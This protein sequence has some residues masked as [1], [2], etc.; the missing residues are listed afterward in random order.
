MERVIVMFSGGL[1]SRLAVKIM[2]EQG[3]EVLA[4]FFKLPFRSGC[5]NNW[6]DFGISKM[7]NVEFRIIDCTKGKNLR[8]YLEILRRPKFKRGS[9]INPCIDCRL[10]MFKKAREIADKE[11]IETIVSGEV[12]GERP[13]SQMQKSLDIVEEESG[14]KGRLLR[15]L[16]AKLLEETLAEKKGYVNR[17][18]LYDIEGRQRIKQ[19]ELAKKFNIKYPTPAGGCLLCEKSLSR[20]FLVL[21][22]KN[23]TEDQ[24]KI[25]GIGRH[26]IIDNK[27]VAI[28]RNLNENKLIVKYGRNYGVFVSNGFA[29][30]SAVL[31][32]KSDEEIQ[33]KIGKLI[34]AYSKNGSL[35]ARKEFEKFRL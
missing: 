14:L 22:G 11:G 18:K 16:S 12:L 13:M 2:Q 33:N 26:F 10:F 20:R 28:G 3:L 25:L 29:G 35:D 27:W 21:L 6:K 31:F 23:L 7:K 24:I 5:C 8:E 1:D 17:D 4:L 32:D 9:G 30:P 34:L 15:P 19:I